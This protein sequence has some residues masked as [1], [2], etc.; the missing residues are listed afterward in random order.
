MDSIKSGDKN[1]TKH[2]WRGNNVLLFGSEG[3]GFKISDSKNS[4][5]L[6][7]IKLIVKLKVLIFPIPHL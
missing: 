4:D 7:K 6:L 2:D 5:F 1:F 3:Y